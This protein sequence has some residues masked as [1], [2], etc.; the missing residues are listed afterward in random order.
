MQE[1]KYKYI[2]WTYVSSTGQLVGGIQ[3]FK[4]LTVCRMQ[5]L[6]S[7]FFYDGISCSFVDA[8]QY[9][10]YLPSYMALSLHAH[11]YNLV[12]HS[13]GQSSGADINRQVRSLRVPL[14]ST[15]QLTFFPNLFSL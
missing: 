12:T 13:V 6:K 9:F 5:R 2:Y 8:N 4:N 1:T 15:V 11:C 7:C 3:Q 10:T 14:P